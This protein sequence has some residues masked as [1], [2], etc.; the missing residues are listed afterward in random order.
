MPSL[1][2]SAI[3]GDGLSDKLIR[4][5]L[6]ILGGLAEEVLQLIRYADLDVDSGFM[7]WRK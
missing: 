6:K 7:G 5:D 2:L 3:G 1:L 4:S